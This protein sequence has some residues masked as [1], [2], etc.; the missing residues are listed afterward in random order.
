MVSFRLLG[1]LLL[2]VWMEGCLTV[3]LLVAVT[4]FGSRWLVLGGVGLGIMWLVLL[5]LLLLLWKEL[6]IAVCDVGGVLLLML[7]QLLLLLFLLLLLL[8]LLLGVFRIQDTT[9]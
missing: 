7:M 3:G 6:C 9:G 4:V 8:L 5:L 1:L 2:L